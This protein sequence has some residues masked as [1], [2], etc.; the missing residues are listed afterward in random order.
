MKG[1]NYV[2]VVSEIDLFYAH[3]EMSHIARGKRE[4]VCIL[5]RY[6]HPQ[7]NRRT[8]VFHL[9]NV[10]LG[11]IKQ[12]KP[13]RDCTGVSKVL[14][15]RFDVQEHALEQIIYE[16]AFA[17]PFQLVVGQFSADFLCI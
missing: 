6:P 13:V 10:L 2:L 5:R 14:K 9:C 11:F 12:F 7:M 8:P 15:A 4:H 1:F 17:L 3:S 16:D